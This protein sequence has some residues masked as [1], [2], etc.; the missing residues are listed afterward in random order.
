M[1]KLLT[2]AAA[3]GAASALSYGQGV[4]SFTSASVFISTNSVVGGPATGRVWSS[5]VAPNEY[6]FALLV[7]PSSQNTIDA[8]LTGWTLSSGTDATSG[9]NGPNYAV[10]TAA[11]RFSGN[12]TTDPGVVVQGFNPGSSADFA[13]VAWSG[14]IGTTLSAFQ[15]WYNGGN[16]ATTGWYAISGVANDVLVGGGAISVPQIMGTASG[17]APAFTLQRLD[18]V[19][20]PT[21]FALMGLG[22]AAMMIFRRRK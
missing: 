21:S 19:P 4:V 15:Q 20:E 10:N 6:Y 3:L 16:V 9:H 2:L 18:P 5:T 11:G 12:Y 22:A 13:I 1:K 17:T 8:S 7:A 14:N